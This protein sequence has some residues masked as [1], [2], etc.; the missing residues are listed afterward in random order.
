[1]SYDRM[2]QR[3]L[4]WT[5]I[6][7]LSMAVIQECDKAHAAKIKLSSYEKILMRVAKVEGDRFGMGDEMQAILLQESVAGRY[8]PIG[9]KRFK[10][11]RKRAYGPMQVRFETARWILKATYNH[12]YED[13][14]LFDKLLWDDHF[15]IWVGSLYLKYCKK[16]TMNWEQAV[17]AYNVGLGN[18]LKHNLSYDPGNYLNKIKVHLADTI[19][20]GE[21]KYIYHTIV[22]GD[23]FSKLAK[24][25]LGD[26]KKWKE[27]SNLNTSIIPEK[28]KIGTILTIE[29]P[30]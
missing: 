2:I 8:G 14:A 11:W 22:K 25:Y 30:I 13:R 7:L 29:L 9:D 6:I 26:W 3:F 27:I 4:A 1:M 17:L 15:N 21:K 18:V 12:E 5:V 28:M 10:D 19:R 16:L 24:T 20:F 23:T